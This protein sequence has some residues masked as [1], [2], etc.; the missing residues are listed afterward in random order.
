[1]DAFKRPFGDPVSRI[2]YP[3]PLTRSS[4]S[5]KRAGKGGNRKYEITGNYIAIPYFETVLLFFF[6]SIY[7]LSILLSI[8]KD[9]QD[10][11]KRKEKFSFA[12]NRSIKMKIRVPRD[13]DRRIF[14][15]LFLQ[16]IT[17]HFH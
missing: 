2:G 8:I 11:K 17:F 1:M 3:R 4:I 9:T 12:I 15:P 7:Q 6:H 14:S 13:R 16:R 10:W 5:E